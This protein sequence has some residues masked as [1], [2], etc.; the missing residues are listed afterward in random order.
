M[1]KLACL[2]LVF[3]PAVAL[4]DEMKAEPPD[5]P[6]DAPLAKLAVAAKCSDN[7]SPWRLWCIASD[8]SKGSAAALPSGKVLVGVTVEL[9]DGKDVAAALKDKVSFTAFAID[10][11]NKVKVTT[12]T[13]SNDAEK[14][15]MFEAGAAASLVFKGKAKTAKLPK[16]L[17]GYVKTLKGEHK[18]TNTRGAWTWSGA[19]NGR[20]R[21]VGDFWVVLET[22][23]SGK[24][25][26]FATIL[27]EK[28]E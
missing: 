20:A 1:T 14:K 26:I 8:W 16:D 27:T 5:D 17:A 11:D 18:V 22:P 19:S 24:A 21:K 7:T 13:P 23:K 2:L 3:A 9:E 4:A 28:W 15:S 6:A 25:G 12:V 10:K